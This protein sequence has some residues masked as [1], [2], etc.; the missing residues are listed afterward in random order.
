MEILI[1]TNRLL[2]RQVIDEDEL[3][4]YQLDTDPEVHKYLGNNPSTN[5]DEIRRTIKFIQQ[6]Y[7]DNGIGRFSVI[8]RETNNFIGWAGLKLI[9]EETNGHINYYDLGYRLSQKFWGKGFA[10]ES[11]EAILT[12]GFNEM[13][14]KEIFAIADSGNE[15]SK[16]ILQ[17]IGLQFVE[18]FDYNKIQH[19][20]YK[21]DKTDWI[22]RKSELTGVL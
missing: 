14:L 5:M 19:H 12:Y 18:T 2:I 22:A 17:K 16:N 4:F 20:W 8:E 9:T 6:Q 10:T 3:G 13:Q 1:Q 7:I 15:G 21:I 11:A